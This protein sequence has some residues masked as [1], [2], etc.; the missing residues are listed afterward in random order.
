MAPY[1][2]PRV[3]AVLDALPLGASLKIDRPAIR[4]RLL[5]MHQ[6]TLP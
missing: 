1:K 4:R 3:V 5:E 6:P 2:V